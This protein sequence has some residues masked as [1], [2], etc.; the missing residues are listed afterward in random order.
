MKACIDNRKKT[1]LNRSSHNVVNIGPPTAEIDSG[2]LGHP[3]ANFNWIHVLASLLHRRR[4]TKV[5]QTLY[6][7]WLSPGLI[8]Y[9]HFGDS[10]PLAEFCQVQNSLCVQVLR[11]PILAALLH[12]TR[13]V[14][15]S[16]TLRRGR[17]NIIT[18]LSLLVIFN[19]GR[20]LYSE[21]GHHVGHRPT[22]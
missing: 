11:S 13:A 21:G 19:R 12:G 7:V 4:S 6:D 20:H 3:I 14:L 17:R 8:H 9:V 22:F 10:F 15:V 16:Q 5:N 1:L 18:E 2:S